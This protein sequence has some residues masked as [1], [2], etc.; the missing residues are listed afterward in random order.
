MS[1]IFFSQEEQGYPQASLLALSLLPRT[2]HLDESGVKR[3]IV[4]L[5][6]LAEELTAIGSLLNSTG[7]PILF[8]A[9]LIHDG[10]YERC[11]M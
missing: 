8:G 6:K 5:Q 2:S 4:S 7:F 1:P 9:G 10:A 3:E 11:Y